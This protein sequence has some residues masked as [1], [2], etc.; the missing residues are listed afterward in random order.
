MLVV[1]LLAFQRFLEAPDP[2]AQIR[3]LIA[4]VG[5]GEGKSM[6]V[7]A[8]A[9][10]VVVA[11]KKKVHVV[12]DD[13]TLLDRDFAAFRRLF[14][15][16]SVVENGKRRPLTAMLCV[17]EERLN[18]SKGAQGQQLGFGCGMMWVLGGQF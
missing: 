17:S 12:V 18:A 14:E 15:A 11:L 9:I 13:E 1:C 7:A 4:Q 8:L 16:F 5:T 3:A 6:I 2:T 10:Y